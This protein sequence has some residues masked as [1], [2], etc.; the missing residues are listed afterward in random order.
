MQTFNEDLEKLT[1]NLFFISESD[2]P[3]KPLYLL[4]K[5]EKPTAEVALKLAGKPAGEKIKELKLADFLLPMTREKPWLPA[6]RQGPT[7]R[8]RAL[9]KFLGDNLRDIRVYKIGRIAMDVCVLGID[10]EGNLAG[11]KT[12]VVE[13]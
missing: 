7:R 13:T 2:Y 11:F 9:E 1:K 12:K 8:F 4:G 6:D 3:L 10:K 5:N